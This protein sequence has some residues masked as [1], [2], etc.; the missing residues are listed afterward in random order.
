[1]VKKCLSV[2]PKAVENI[3]KCP[4]VS[5]IQKILNFFS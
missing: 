5:K 1:M 2:F 3:M 4:N